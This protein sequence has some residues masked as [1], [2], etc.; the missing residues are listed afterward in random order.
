ML[1]GGIMSYPFFIDVIDTDMIMCF[2]MCSQNAVLVLHMVEV[3]PTALREYLHWF[4]E[5][6]ST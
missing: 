6:Q 3:Y 2:A 1:C 4:H 5:I